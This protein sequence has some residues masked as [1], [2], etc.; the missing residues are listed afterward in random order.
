M[1]AARELMAAARQNRVRG[2]QAM[3]GKL[4]DAGLQGKRR[5]VGQGVLVEGESTN[6]ERG[7]GGGFSLIMEKLTSL[8]E[9]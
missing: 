9:R 4:K 1:A 6:Q 8:Q 2:F 5:G 3:A 7:G